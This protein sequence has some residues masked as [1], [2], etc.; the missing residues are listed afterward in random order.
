[1]NVGEAQAPEAVPETTE[2][3][4]SG[5]EAEAVCRELGLFQ[6]RLTVGQWAA[7][8]QFATLVSLGLLPTPFIRSICELLE[9]PADA[10]SRRD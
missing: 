2:G 5:V 1:M 8:A 10:Q 6:H 3:L 4:V 7:V 9:A